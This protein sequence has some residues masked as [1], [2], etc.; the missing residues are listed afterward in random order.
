MKKVMLLF[1]ILLVTAVSLANLYAV[2]TEGRVVLL[3][4]NGTW[5]Y[6]DVQ[7]GSKPIVEID[8]PLI[9]GDLSITLKEIARIDKEYVVLDLLVQ[10]NDSEPK[11]FVIMVLYL[12]DKQGYTYSGTFMFDPPAK[13]DRTFE[14]D[15]IAPNGGIS[16]GAV[17]FQ[18]PKSTTLVKLI[19]DIYPAMIFDIS[20]VAEGI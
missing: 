2:T 17:F 7:L 20:K 3:K 16:R 1:L 6:E 8:K 10:N 5:K 4:S 14:A 15:H 9:A 13:Y 12:R 18:I 11:A 19:Y